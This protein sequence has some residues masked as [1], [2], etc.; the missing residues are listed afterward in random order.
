[1][2]RQNVGH[3]LR[4]CPVNAARCGRCEDEVTRCTNRQTGRPASRRGQSIARSGNRRDAGNNFAA[5]AVRL[6][7]RSDKA[8]AVQT[9]LTRLSL[10]HQ[11]QVHVDSGPI[12]VKCSCNGLLNGL[13]TQIACAKPFI[14]ALKFL[15]EIELRIDDVTYFGRGDDVVRI[16]VIDRDKSE[17][18]CP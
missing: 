15:G 12:L 6:Y 18:C 3:V 8:G 4:E 16:G 13:E 2:R 1:M 11:W 14:C 9:D 10:R 7:K 17:T 5:I